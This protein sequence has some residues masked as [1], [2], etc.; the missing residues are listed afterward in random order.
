MAAV[1]SD[2]SGVAV[3][4]LGASPAPEGAQVRLVM[5]VGGD[6]EPQMVEPARVESAP[7]RPKAAPPEHDK[8]LPIPQ[9][10]IV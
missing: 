3:K 10:G 4:A 6:R 1:A 7:E 5:F 9:V 2:D 8:P